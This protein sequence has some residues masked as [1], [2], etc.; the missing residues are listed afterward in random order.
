MRIRYLEIM[1]SRLKPHVPYL[2]LLLA[3]IAWFHWRIGLLGEVIQG[4]D[5]LNQFI[6]WRTMALQ[7]IQAG[8]FP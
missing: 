2:V 4:G 1:F 6:P 7:E 8:R 5:Y 3:P